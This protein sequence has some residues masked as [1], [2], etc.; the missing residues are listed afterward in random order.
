MTRKNN[1]KIISVV[2]PICCGL[3]V[4]KK[5]VSACIII[6]ES[7]GEQT[8]MIQEFSTF[9]DDLYRLKSWL[10]SH[11][12]PVVAMESTSVYWRPVHNVLEDAFKVILV[13]A[14]HVKNVPGRKTDI[15]DSMWL[16]SLLRIGVLKASFIPLETFNFKSDSS[17]VKGL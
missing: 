1:N 13:N 8:F 5:S 3:D 17:L 10:S 14:K 6:T 7:D 2:H 4:H 11:A 12:C 15:S 9:T 16:A